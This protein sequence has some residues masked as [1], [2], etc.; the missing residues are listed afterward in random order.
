MSAQPDTLPTSTSTST[1]TPVAASARD[2][3][4]RIVPVRRTGQW[5]AATAV[6]V[7]LAMAVNSVVRNEAFPW[8]VVGDDFTSTAVLRGLGHAR[9]TAGAR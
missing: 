3:Q 4:P 9:G 5:T 2:A 6:L 1:P 7:L 8:A